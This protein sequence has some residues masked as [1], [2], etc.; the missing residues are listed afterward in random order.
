MT[1]SKAR[2]NRLLRVFGRGGFGEGRSRAS[3][4]GGSRAGRAGVLLAVLL[5]AMLPL[6]QQLASAQDSGVVPS[7]GDAVAVVNGQPVDGSASGGGSAGGGLAAPVQDPTTGRWLDRQN[8]FVLDPNQN[9]WVDPNTGAPVVAGWVIDPS[10]GA[11]ALGD[12]SNGVSGS[13]AAA[14]ADASATADPS[15]A[16]ADAS[17][18]ADPSAAPADASATAAPDT[19]TADQSG[20]GALPQIQYVKDP[21]TGGWI[22]PNTG[23]LVDPHSLPYGIDPN[24]GVPVQAD[25]TWDGGDFSVGSYWPAG[26]DVYPASTAGPTFQWAAPRTVY[27][28]DTGHSIDGYFLDVWRQ[29]GGAASWGDPISA[30]FT[31]DGRT[32]QYFAYGRFEWWPEDQQLHY[33]NLGAQTQ[34]FALR[35]GLPGTGKAMTDL[36]ASAKAWNAMLP[37]T[38]PAD[39]DTSTFVGDTGHAVQGDFKAFWEATGTTSY[40]GNPVSE[41]FRLGSRTLQAFQRGV[42]AEDA[43]G[44]PFLLPIGSII[45]QRWA[46]DTSPTDQGDLPTYSESLFVQPASSTLGQ[47]VDPNAARWVKISISQQYAWAMQGDVVVWEG[48][49]STGRSGYDTP[50]GEFQVLRK[51]PSQTMAG[52]LGGDFYNVPNVP[53]VMYFTDEGHALHGTY[54]HHNFGTPMSHGCVNL[55]MDVADWMYQWAPVGMR[56]SIVP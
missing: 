14:P 18:T 34:P 15:A 37:G 35:R 21:N 22:D 48:Y 2:G 16:P 50:T 45:T 38:A 55:P 43:G 10:T 32:E 6:W 13:G 30:E 28:P 56:V 40:L 19:A 33:G 49:V 12:D 29:W 27:L 41:P 8:G 52:V 47:A 3:R 1:L 44:S 26:P 25:Q 54:W 36:A 4:G 42:V 46:V 11:W 39:S 20:G 7:V 9:R 17:A 5:F 31:I 23:Q 51:L 24:T 53:D